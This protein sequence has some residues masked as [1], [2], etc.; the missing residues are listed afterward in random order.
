MLVGK[1]LEVAGY[2]DPRSV[3]RLFRLGR[4]ET[5]RTIGVLARSGALLTDQEIVGLPGRWLI[6]TRL[7]R[8]TGVRRACRRAP[9]TPPCY[10]TLTRVPDQARLRRDSVPAKVRTPRHPRT[11][12]AHEA[13]Q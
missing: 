10:V 5:E 2:A 7:I 3:A 8:A 11:P 6:S 4:E 12:V 13:T 1:F 9:P